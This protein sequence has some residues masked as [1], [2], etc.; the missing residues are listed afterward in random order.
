MRPFSVAPS[1]LIIFCFFT[2]GFTPGYILSALRA[3]CRAKKLFALHEKAIAV[4]NLIYIHLW[5][6]LLKILHINTE[7]TWRGGEQQVLYLAKGLAAK[8]HTSTIICQ[9]GSPLAERAKK[10]GLAVVEMSMRGGFDLIAIFK[11]ACQLR[12]GYDILHLHTSNA[13][14]IGYFASLLKRGHK[15]VVTRRVSFPIKG[16]WG[17]LKYTGVDKL[18]AVC[19][20]VRN[21]LINSGIPPRLV[22]A[23]HS[24]IDLS[25][26]EKRRVEPSE[27]IVGNVAHLAEHKGHKYFLEAAKNVLTVIPTAKFIIVGDG[28]LRSELERYAKGLAIADK[29][30]FP[31]FQKDIRRFIAQCTITVL[32]SI[33]GEGSPGVLKESMSIGVPV[34]TT[35]VGGSREVVADGISG[36]V[37]PPGNPDALSSAIIR[38]LRDKELRERIAIEGLVKVKEF[39]LDAIVDKTEAVYRELLGLT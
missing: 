25:R 12:T 37:V 36:F 24:A 11:I 27:P 32:S 17:K 2:R 15:V 16:L 10:E 4:G 18:I 26:Y 8:G 3:C 9:P 31:G 35:D 19:E 14:T 21:D 13:H 38:L 29:V 20:A 39:S 23:I 7:K 30:S 34:V 28:E 1:G 6:N 33:S 22:V 5:L